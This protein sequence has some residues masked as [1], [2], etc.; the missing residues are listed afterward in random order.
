MFNLTL[1]QPRLKQCLVLFLLSLTS[2]GCVTSRSE[3]LGSVVYEPRPENHPIFVFDSLKDVDRP[4]VKVGVV[5]SDGAPAASWDKMTEALKGRARAIGADALV[6]RQE[7]GD[8]TQGV[9]LFGEGGSTFGTVRSR[10]KKS[11]LAI[12]FTN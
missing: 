8:Q 5:H 10:K 6:L 11:C 2:V 3:L 7:S 9:V 12:R 1:P 4:Y